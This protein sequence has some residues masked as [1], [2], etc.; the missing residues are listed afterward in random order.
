MWIKSAQE[1]K[2]RKKN[3]KNRKKWTEMLNLEK[4][5]KKKSVSFNQRKHGKSKSIES[6][7]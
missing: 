6:A 5:L 3:G 2:K 7:L 4:Y 1:K